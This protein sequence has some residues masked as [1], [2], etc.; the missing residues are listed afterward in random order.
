MTLKTCLMNSTKRQYIHIGAVRTDAQKE[1]IAKTKKEAAAIKLE[2]TFKN[3]L[4][5]WISEPTGTAQKTWRQST[6]RKY[7]S[8]NLPQSC[9]D[10]L[11][12]TTGWT[13]SKGT[14][15]TTDSRVQS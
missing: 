8:K 10:M 12:K 1:A 13:F 3:K 2:A 15:H 14:P 9:I 7:H 4:E 6:S 5:W 11:N